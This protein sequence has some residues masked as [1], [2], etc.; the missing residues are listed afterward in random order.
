MP[1]FSPSEDGNLYQWC[2]DENTLMEVIPLTAGISEA[3]VPT[4]IGPDGTVYS[5]NNAILFAVGNQSGQTVSIMSSAP[6]LQNVVAGQP[7]TFTAGVTDT[8]GSGFN[9]TGTITF[10]D[11]S[12]PLATVALDSTGHASYTTSSLP[13]NPSYP[14]ATHFISA[15]YSGDSHFSSGTAM[16]NQTVHESATTTAHHLGA[17]PRLIRAGGDVHSN[18]DTE[19]FRS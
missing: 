2:P 12:T 6:S 18:R 19:H 7:I 11:G 5:I 9:P 10:E 16:L 15:V 13:T 3:Y 1:S 4:V 14:W 8:S 17:Q